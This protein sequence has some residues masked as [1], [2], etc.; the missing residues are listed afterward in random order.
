[1]RISSDNGYE[2]A[3]SETTHFFG[4]RD[5]RRALVQEKLDA[6]GMLLDRM[7]LCDGLLFRFWQMK[8]SATLMSVVMALLVAT[9]IV[10][11]ASA[12]TSPAPT[13]AQQRRKHSN[14]RT[15][16]LKGCGSLVQQSEAWEGTLRGHRSRAFPSR[17]EE[18][19]LA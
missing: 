1:M 14:K 16:H 7:V 8:H 13:P 18:G 11:Q 17:A 9:T 2:T 12:Q 4:V 10:P 5:L 19:Q 6:V 15:G 3:L